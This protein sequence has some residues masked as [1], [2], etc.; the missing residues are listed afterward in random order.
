MFSSPWTIFNDFEKLYFYSFFF[1]TRKSWSSKIYFYNFHRVWPWGVNQL[2]ACRLLCLAS[3]FLEGNPAL[4]ASQTVI[5]TFR[6]QI[7]W[8]FHNF[9]LQRKF[10]SL[11]KLLLAFWLGVF[12]TSLGKVSE[13]LSEFSITWVQNRFY[14]F[15]VNRK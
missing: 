10:R 5:F 11:M 3:R 4:K 8:Y 13:K 6:C 15:F 12:G 2:Y 7:F 14:F 1:K 9:I